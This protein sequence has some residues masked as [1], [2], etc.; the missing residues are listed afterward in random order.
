MTA[1]VVVIGGGFAGLTTAVPLAEA[2]L[3]VVVVEEAPRLGGRASAFTDQFTGERV[4]NGQHV[5]FGCYHETYRFLKAIGTDAL[6]PLDRRLRVAIAGETLRPAA[7][8]C[9]PLPAPWHLAAAILKWNA[10]SLRDRM[11]ALALAPALRSRP[12]GT[13]LSSITVSEWLR[14]HRQPPSLCR[15]LWHPL[16]VAALNQSPDSAAAGPFVEVLRQLFGGRAIDSAIGVPSV[17]LDELFALPAARFVDAH[18]G[19]VLTKTPARVG[20]DARDRITH[21][22][23]GDMRIST[24]I[25]VSAVPWHAV[26]R[27]WERTVPAAMTEVAAVAAAMEALPI[28]TA[29]L[30]FDRPFMPEKFV[31]LVDGPMHWAF[32]KSRI[33]GGEAG[34]ISMVSSGAVDLVDLDR[35]AVT[36]MAR[37]QLDRTL[38]GARGAQLR[39]SIV[40]RERRATFSVAPG[41]PARPST[42][43]GLPGFFL[44]GDWTDTGLP[45]TIESA[46][47]SGRRAAEAVL[48]FR[49]RGTRHNRPE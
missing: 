36:E 45:G 2:G 31:G 27:I 39:R 5:L 28:L 25:V 15:W 40:V 11:R 6:A 18:G 44:A 12:D 16:A 30:W 9:P 19:R 32:D 43:T 14:A 3:V 38:P 46:A 49:S 23:A 21:V 4:D 13:A 42:R 17:P 37:A 7:L 47:L 35:D 26:T 33:F 24:D 34:H 1:D 8:S 22:V 10:V 29:N 41:S 20:L 48:E